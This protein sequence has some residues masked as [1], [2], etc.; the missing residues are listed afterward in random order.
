VL[1]SAQ[2]F[3]V[4]SETVISPV[5]ATAAV[6]EAGV[7]GQTVGNQRGLSATDAPPN[8]AGWNRSSVALTLNSTDNE[9]G[10]T[11][12]KQLAFSATGA[13][14]VSST[15]VNN[16]TAVINLS[17]EGV[18]TVSFNATDGAGNVEPTK[19][20]TVKIHETPPTITVSGISAGTFSLGG[21][22]RRA[23]VR[24]HD[25]PERNGNL[26]ADTYPISRDLRTWRR[27]R[28]R[29]IVSGK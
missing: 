24:G 5:T 7:N 8:S 2:A 17:A 23:S 1:W 14:P 10:G 12:V 4:T 22:H 9:V 13:Q 25:G 15:T 16:S 19:T 20:V 18:T 29:C 3:S 28:G 26:R 27:V 11:G 6:V 21:G